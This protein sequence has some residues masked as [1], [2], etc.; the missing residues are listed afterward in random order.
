MLSTLGPSVLTGGRRTGTSSALST[1][2][3]IERDELVNVQIGRGTH[4]IGCNDQDSVTAFPVE[5]VV[6]RK[7]PHGGS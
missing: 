3:G 4:S 6:N 7:G 2:R 5:P 1:T